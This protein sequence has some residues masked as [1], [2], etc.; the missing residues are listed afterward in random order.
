[1]AIYLSTSQRDRIR[2]DHHLFH[3]G[4]SL[5]LPLSFSSFLSLSFSSFILFFHFWF[6][7]YFFQNIYYIVIL[8]WALLYFYYSFSWT[9]PWS[10]CDNDWNTDRCWSSVSSAGHHNDSTLIPSIHLVNTSD[11]PVV[12]SAKEFWEKKILQ[13]QNV[14]DRYI[15]F[16]NHHLTFCHSSTRKM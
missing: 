3:T 16:L 4:E 5:S 10:T 14:S 1:M 2:N 8:S 6:F 7:C 12:D 13:V 9:L 15:F 11:N